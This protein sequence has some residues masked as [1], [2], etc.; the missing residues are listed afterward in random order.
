[1]RGRGEQIVQI[2]KLRRAFAGTRR[3]GVVIVNSRRRRRRSSSSSTRTRTG[4]RSNRRNNIDRM[5]IGRGVGKKRAGELVSKS[6]CRASMREREQIQLSNNFRVDC[7]GRG[8]LIQVCRT[9]KNSNRSNVAVSV[10]SFDFVRF[11]WFLEISSLCEPLTCSH[12]THRR[13]SPFVRIRSA[14]TPAS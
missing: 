8:S 1:M 10:G 11:E 3:R 7:G 14:R 13:Q 5:N 6:F 4:N 9:L 2:D 12:F